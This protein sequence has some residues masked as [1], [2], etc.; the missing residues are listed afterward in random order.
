[1]TKDFYGKTI[2]PLTYVDST[3]AKLGDVIRW[4]VWDNEDYTTW[5]MTGIYNSDS[6]TYLG[7]G[8]DFGYAI[9]K[10]ES[11]EEVI[12]EAENNDEWCRGIT[13]VGVVGELVKCIADFGN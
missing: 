3:Q 8:C 4:S 12:E 11:V 7:G 2:I 10:E 9:G 1:M 13:K 6:V 5:T